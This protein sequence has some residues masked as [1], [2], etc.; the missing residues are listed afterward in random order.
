MKIEIKKQKDN[1]LLNRT[2]VKFE[3]DHANSAT[4]N[5]TDVMDMVA[6]KTNRDKKFIVIKQINTKY[7]ENISVGLAYIY[8]DEKSMKA[9]P[10]YSLKRGQEKK[11]KKEEAPAEALMEEIPEASAKPKEEKAEA[12]EE[13]QEEVKS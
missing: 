9:E 8:N 2:E 12:P 3:I 1:H 13:K 10:K 6:T 5:R 4:P 11:A 7:G